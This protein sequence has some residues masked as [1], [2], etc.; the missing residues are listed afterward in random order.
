MIL[1]E[2]H[3]KKLI[4]P[5]HFILANTQ[6]LTIMGSNAYGV[7]DTNVKDKVPDFDVYGFCI[8]PKEYIFPHLRGEIPGFGT[9]GTKFDQWQQPHIL[10]PDAN[11][12]RGKEWDFQIFNIVKMFEL[13]RQGNPNMLDS[14]FTPENCI[15]HITQVGR[16][17]RDN[18]KLF[19]SKLVWDKFRGYAFSQMAKLESKQSRGLNAVKK[20]EEDHEISNKTKM[21]D[22]LAEIR[23][24]GLKFEPSNVNKRSQRLKEIHGSTKRDSDVGGT[25]TSTE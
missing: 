9:A 17:V 14:L 11:M 3:K 20:F 25:E 18:R 5:P 16:K 19:V 7:A 2:L 22:I 1:D 13:C 24:R 21:Q 4:A 10:D 12:G 15:V 6:Y 23:R 8:P